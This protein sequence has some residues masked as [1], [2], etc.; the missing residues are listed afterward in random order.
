MNPSAT[1]PRSQRPERL[2]KEFLKG[3][4]QACGLAWIE[5]Q[6]SDAQE[7]ASNPDHDAPSCQAEAFPLHEYPPSYSPT[8]LTKLEVFLEVSLVSIVEFVEA[9]TNHAYTDSQRNHPAQRL[10]E[11]RRRP[12]LRRL[13]P[14]EVT[15][16]C[17][18]VNARTE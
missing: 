8:Y 11:K 13:P 7:D 10:R 2:T 14:P 16:N 1:T 5:L 4:T 17:P 9:V 12:I 6:C 18:A 3:A 15:T